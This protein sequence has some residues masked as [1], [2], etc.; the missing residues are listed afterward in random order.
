M[1]S[2][3]VLDHF[4]TRWCRFGG[5]ISRSRDGRRAD[6][7]CDPATRSRLLATRL[8]SAA[9]DPRLTS[10]PWPGRDRSEERHEPNGAWSDA[11]AQRRSEGGVHKARPGRT[12]GD[13][14]A[15]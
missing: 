2:L 9:V 3:L 4:N 11:Q 15:D 8:A 13:T 7:G 10:A 6:K 1:S 5:M 14:A 12:R